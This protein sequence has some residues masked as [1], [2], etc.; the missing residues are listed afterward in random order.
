MTPF[1][2]VEPGDRLRVEIAVLA[3]RPGRGVDRPATWSPMNHM[4]AAAGALLLTALLAACG[5]EDSAQAPAPPA[6]STPTGPVLLGKGLIKDGVQIDTDKP[7]AFSVSTVTFPPG[8]G[9]GWHT[10]DGSEIFIVT[11][12]EVTLVRE[13]GCDPVVFRVGDAGFVPPNTPHVGT[14]TGAGP[15]ELVVTRLLAP[16]APDRADAQSACQ[17]AASLPPSPR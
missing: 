2:R 6:T 13:G 11:K 5:D 17:D 14:N 1:Q 8:G 4:R 16:D 12:G 7:A 15:A 3:E 9:T 10:H